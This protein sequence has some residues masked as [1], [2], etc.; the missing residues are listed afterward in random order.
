TS[1]FVFMS[2]PRQFV[3][4][5]LN[6]HRV[7]QTEVILRSLTRPNTQLPSPRGA[8][9]TS[10]PLQRWEERNEDLSPGGTTQHARGVRSQSRTTAGAI[11]NSLAVIRWPRTAITPH[12]N[13]T[14]ATASAFPIPISLAT[15]P[16]R[17]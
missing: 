5:D 16:Q 1:P 2:P 12:A 15:A 14:A 10:P 3:A 4:A 7:V 11:S 9:Q 6:T 13:T 8:N 17:L